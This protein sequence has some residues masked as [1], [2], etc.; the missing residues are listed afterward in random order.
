MVPLSRDALRTDGHTASP[1]GRLHAIDVCSADAAKSCAEVDCDFGCFD[2]KADAV[3]GRTRRF[4]SIHLRP[5]DGKFELGQRRNSGAGKRGQIYLSKLHAKIN[6]SPFP[7]EDNYKLYTKFRTGSS[8][9]TFRDI[10]EN[11]LNHAAES[12]GFYW[13][14]TAR[15]VAN[16]L[17]LNRYADIS[18]RLELQELSNI[19]TNYSY[20][21]RQ[22]LV[23]L[24]SIDYYLSPQ[25]EPVARGVNTGN[26]TGTG[27]V[28][29]LTLRRVVF[30][31]CILTLTEQF[32]S[33]NGETFTFPSIVARQ[34]P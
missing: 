27:V 4:C 20:P 32:F 25:L 10:I 13:I 15:P 29:G 5:R 1:D 6:L 34:L 7:G 12:A 30:S 11:D 23:D 16:S 17:C 19:C 3:R 9:P 24:S 2:K 31:S 21:Q 22:C 18:P 8:T 28:N 14:S 33:E 26:P